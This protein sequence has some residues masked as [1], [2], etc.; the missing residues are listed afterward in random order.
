M[1]YEDKGIAVI[2]GNKKWKIQYKKFPNHEIATYS[3]ESSV[4][5]LYT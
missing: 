2:D 1:T 4:S 3:Q 5:L